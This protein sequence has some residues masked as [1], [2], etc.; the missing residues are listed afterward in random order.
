[1]PFGAHRHAP[2]SGSR[3]RSACRARSGSHGT[4]SAG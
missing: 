3:Q 2:S 4:G 1:L